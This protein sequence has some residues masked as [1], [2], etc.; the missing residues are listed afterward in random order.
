M[1]AP[2]ARMAARRSRDGSSRC[3]P[4]R[5]LEAFAAR[6]L[7][8]TPVNVRIDYATFG[9]SSVGAGPGA[10]P[11]QMIGEVSVNGVT[12]PLR[13]TTYYYPTAFDQTMIEQSNF[14]RMQQ[15]SE[16]FASWA[17]TGA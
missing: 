14:D 12:R 11:D 9:P 2:C 16:A 1:L 7:A 10:S 15:L 17:A 13:A 8:G 3:C 5:L 4:E 6:G